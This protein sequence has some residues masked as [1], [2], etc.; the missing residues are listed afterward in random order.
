[1]IRRWIL[2]SFAVILAWGCVPLL[3]FSPGR[4]IHTPDLD[5]PFDWS[6]WHQ[7]TELW[8]VRWGAGVEWVL[9]LP[10]AIAAAF[11]AAIHEWTRSLA[12]AQRLDF[13]LWFTLPGVT[14]WLLMYE[15]TRAQRTGRWAECLVAVNVYMFNM[16]LESL[17]QG[18]LAGLTAYAALPLLLWMIFRGLES[19]RPAAWGIGLGLSSLLWS[20]IGINL[21][22]ATVVVAVVLGLLLT[23]G[24]RAIVRR[25]RVAATRALVLAV[26][27]MLMTMACQAF[28]LIPHWSTFTSAQDAAIS[29]IRQDARSWLGTVSTYTSFAN[30][31]RL[32]GAWTWDQ[33][34]QEPYHRYAALFRNHPLWIGLSWLLPLCV[35]LGITHLRGWRRGYFGILAIVGLLL[36]LGIHTPM[37]ELYIWMVKH[38]PLFW[39]FRTPWY[40]FSL[41]T[42]LGYAVLAAVGVRWLYERWRV[43]APR[44]ATTGLA[45]ALV[46]N[47][48]FAFPVTLGLMFPRPEERKFLKPSHVAIPPHVT[49]S[50]AWLDAHA[51]ESRTL[52]L[53]RH[54]NNLGVYNWGYVAFAPPISL[55]AKAPI[56]FSSGLWFSTDHGNAMAGAV[57]DALYAASTCDALKI[58][59][60]LGVR[61]LLLEG[62]LEYDYFES[63][64]DSP[65]FIRRQL[66]RQRGWA[67]VR[68]E[69]P[70]EWYE[71][72]LPSLPRW[73]VADSVIAVLGD[74]SAMVWLTATPLL[75][76]RP[77]CLFLQDQQGAVTWPPADIGPL[78]RTTVAI[79]Q[80]GPVP[81][82]PAWWLAAPDQYLVQS[83]EQFARAIVPDTVL[84]ETIVRV[85]E[86][87][88]IDAMETLP[89]GTTWGWLSVANEPFHLVVE[90]RTPEP[91][92]TEWQF[93]VRS[94]TQMR[95]LHVYLNNELINVATVPPDL[96][97][98]VAPK[99]LTLRP[100]RNEIRFYTPY[101]WD[102]QGARQVAFAFQ[103]GSFRFGRLERRGL[104][105]IPRAGSFEV[106]LT[107]APLTDDEPERRTVW[108][109]EQTL[110]AERIAP[111]RWRVPHPVALSEG[112]V[113]F[114]YHQRVMDEQVTLMMHQGAPAEPASSIATVSATPIGT[115]KYLVQVSGSSPTL[116]VFQDAYHRF[117]RAVPHDPQVPAP[118]HLM[119]NGFANGFLLGSPA[120]DRL[121]VTFDL[122]DRFR[123]GRRISLVAM[124]IG[125]VF[126]LG[127]VSWP[128]RR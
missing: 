4:L 79:N 27:A 71:V 58:A 97:T 87:R 67:P 38:L 95:Q 33:G 74:R 49:T 116:V 69:G 68:Q 11:P 107:C 86:Q 102:W 84:P 15:L 126:W 5:I 39:I 66:A 60:L 10:I 8:N 13:I 56:M 121:T 122:Q 103:E 83:T 24:V 16:Y 12:I 81:K 54:V 18:N 9:P 91:L 50:A 59:R 115:A 55:F 62:D 99:P 80:Q 65:A 123:L 45:A 101:A 30:V 96:P 105:W 31:A 21:E 1:M 75:N 114:A 47:M 98:E 127:L 70:W 108:L 41:M 111:G 20:T 77:G 63:D 22:V 37:R 28:W 82:T 93:R 109:A 61:Y 40:K 88:G 42:S 44:L 57:H 125:G 85:A 113:E 14:L 94:P 7:L 25:D 26:T 52:C 48:A 64:G 19:R 112:R 51:G 110:M 29:A 73:Y 117:W 32:Q 128:H 120:S 35:W 100:G 104:V 23:A 92:K 53:Q 36:G 43:A 34:W 124:V 118:Q 106:T 72:T 46:G 17:W 2:W 3:W 78:V 6:R 90:N 89:D 76:G 119:V